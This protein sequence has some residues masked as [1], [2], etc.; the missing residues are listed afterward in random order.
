MPL[1]NLAHPHVL[2]ANVSISLLALI[3]N[4]PPTPDPAKGCVP[5]P[6]L[7]DDQYLNRNGTDSIRSDLPSSVSIAFFVYCIE[8]FQILNDV[9]TDIYHAPYTDR[10][11]EKD[12]HTWWPS[13]K[14]SHISRLNTR[15]DS[16]ST[17]VPGHLQNSMD[18]PYSI[19]GHSIDW[20]S[21]V[22]RCR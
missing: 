12:P 21:Y 13:V 6:S 19:L 4:Q 2:A 7:I 1:S 5:L 15:L 11:F 9:L 20:Q 18:N 8:L 14:L 16:L 22:F 17:Q 3:F 10:T